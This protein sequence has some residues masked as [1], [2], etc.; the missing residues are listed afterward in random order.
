MTDGSAVPPELILNTKSGAL[1][2][3]VGS[4]KKTYRFKISILTAQNSAAKAHKLELEK[5]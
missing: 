4:I 3:G 2:V 5:L 1:Q